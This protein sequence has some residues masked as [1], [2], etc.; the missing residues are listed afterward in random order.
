MT[1][2]LMDGR[3]EELLSVLAEM[4]N[5][6]SLGPKDISPEWNALEAFEPII[7]EVE[8]VFGRYDI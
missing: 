2:I 7:Q 1:D 4:K 8:R 5:E 6:G 3:K